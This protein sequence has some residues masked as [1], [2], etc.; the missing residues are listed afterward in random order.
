MD[1]SRFCCDLL[2]NS[3]ILRKRQQN[4]VNALTLS[5]S[6]KFSR[7]LHNI[8]AVLAYVFRIIPIHRNKNYDHPTHITIFMVRNVSRVRFFGGSERIRANLNHFWSNRAENTSK[9]YQSLV[10]TLT[11]GCLKKFSKRF[12]DMFEVLAHFLGIISTR[13]NK[14]D[15]HTTLGSIFIA[16]NVSCVRFFGGSEWI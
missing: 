4:L 2:Q 15:G 8:S 6:K 10:D 7:G 16:A 12:Q 5:C 14:R 3:S 11:L 9:T 13:R 1:L